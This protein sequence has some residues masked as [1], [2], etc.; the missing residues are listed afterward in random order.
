M[1]VKKFMPIIFLTVFVVIFFK[2]FFLQNKLPIPADTIIGLYHPFR[3]LYAK[4]YPRGIPFKNFLIT[5]PV[6]QQY[7][8][9]QLA[10]SL[11]KKIQLPLWNPYNAAGAP[12]LANFQTAAW[13]PFNILFFIFPFS[14]AW[15]VLVVLQPLLGG[16]FLYFYLRQ[17]FI[18]KWGSILGAIAF[19]FSGFSIAWLEWNTIGHAMLWLP[20]LLLS[21]DKIVLRNKPLIWSVVFLFSLCSSFFA[22]HLQTFFYL[23]LITLTYFIVRWIQNRRDKKIIS[24]FI[25]LYSLFFIVTAIQWIPTLQFVGESARSIDQADWQK[26]GWFIPWQHLLQFVAP[27]F[28][29]NPTT[30]NYWGVWNYAEFIGYVGIFPLIMALYALFFRRDK[31]TLFFGTFLF[32]SL[33]FSLPTFFAKIPYLFNIPFLSTAQPTRLLFITDFSLAVLCALGFDYFLR[34]KKGILSAISFIGIVFVG[35]WLFASTQSLAVA[36]QN[37]FLP[38]FIFVSAS[39][40]LIFL[41][42]LSK[43]N[44]RIIIMIYIIIVGITVF[45]LLRFGQKFTPITNKEYL[46]S[47]SSAISFLQQQKGYF[48]IM[49]TDDRILPPNFSTIYRLQSIDGY[50]PL[51]LLRYGEL[52]A[53]S[54]RGKP[55][56]SPP[57][58][59]NRIITPHV[60][61]SKIIDLLGVKYI[62][63]L[64][65]IKSPKLVKVF[66]EGQTRIYENTSALPRT[67][68]V[69]K[70]H[71]GFVKEDLIKFLFNDSVNFRDEAI[72]EGEGGFPMSKEVEK[73]KA[74]IIQYTENSISIKTENF[75]QSFLVL[76]DMYYPAWH[77]YI[78]GKETKI[79]RTNYTFRGVFVPNGKHI[80]EFNIGLL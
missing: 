27:D 22:G 47:Q 48:R 6:R 59:F 67:F 4:Q 30:L 51:Y 64:S 10:I 32:L 56:I 55:D 14:F 50:D 37:L 18:N 23:F 60:Y 73:N 69:S 45:D 43:I 12:L 71:Q 62:L 49:T 5:D 28:F 2:A 68:F 19:S 1:K 52:I 35:A 54:E 9:R 41:W 75:G 61:N 36:K 46:F 42:K 72:L 25:I 3:D 58:G 26:E 8:W 77:A 57:F 20:L 76:T 16:V 21:I 17:L 66:Q 38:S 63:S 11:E 74:E 39:S 70:I 79:Y 33:I 7:P 29:G 15:S 24:L 13:Y 34:H 40:L 31:K 80:I 65:D 78:D 44:Q 53:A